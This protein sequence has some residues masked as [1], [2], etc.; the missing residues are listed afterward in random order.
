MEE[1]TSVNFY[2][3]VLSLEL[4]M[5]SCHIWLLYFKVLKG[6]YYGPELQCLWYLMC[7][8]DKFWS[9]VIGEEYILKWTIR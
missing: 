7:S 6:S 2:K 8:V 1:F 9:V 4:I 3:N 5:I